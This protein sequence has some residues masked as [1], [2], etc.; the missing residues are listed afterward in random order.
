MKLELYNERPGIKLERIN[1]LVH[2][3]NFRK[4]FLKYYVFLRALFGSRPIFVRQTD[5]DSR[6]VVFWSPEVHH[7]R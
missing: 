5:K 6:E 1:T 4:V 2:Q 3:V 7:F